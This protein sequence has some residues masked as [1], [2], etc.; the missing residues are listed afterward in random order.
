MTG[1]PAGFGK[2]VNTYL[3][4]YVRVADAKAAAFLAANFAATTLALRIG[5]TTTLPSVCRWLAL[6]AFAISTCFC[7]WTLY[8]RLPKGHM[9]VVFWEDIMCFNKKELYITEL[10]GMDEEAVEVEYAA[11]NWFVSK[12]VHKKLLA[13]Q[14]AILW[15]V[16]AVGLAVL[17]YLALP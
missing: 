5:P 11:Q 1:P 6:A 12:V 13:V 15:F 3:N 7:A 8:P 4:D 9:G 2:G 17:S 14:R 10:K 16:T